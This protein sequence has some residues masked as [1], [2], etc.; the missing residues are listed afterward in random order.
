MALEGGTLLV[1]SV[2]ATSGSTAV[3]LLEQSAK[4]AWR[5]LAQPPPRRTK[6]APATLALTSPGLVFEDDASSDAVFVHQIARG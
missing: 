2:G 1:A 5:Y 3:T 4:G 6:G